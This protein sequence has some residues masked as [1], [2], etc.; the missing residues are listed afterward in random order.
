ME[1]Y[2]R[3]KSINNN[4]KGR[5]ITLAKQLSN[6]LQIINVQLRNL[7]DFNKLVSRAVDEKNWKSFVNELYEKYV[8]QQ[9]LLEE[10][11]LIKRKNNK[12]NNNNDDNINKKIK[13]NDDNN[14]IDLLNKKMKLRKIIKLNNNNSNNNNNNDNNNNIKKIKNCIDIC[15]KI[16]NKKM[17]E[18]VD[19]RKRKWSIERRIKFE[20]MKK[21]KKL[22][23]DST[24]A[25]DKLF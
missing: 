18:N 5:K 14:N 2:Y 20:E 22:D 19:S 17:K 24:R 7:E 9:L 10:K 8:E 6:D 15:E 3:Y 1:C 21:L 25:F 23:F 4:F 16:E 11:T 13:K 12:N